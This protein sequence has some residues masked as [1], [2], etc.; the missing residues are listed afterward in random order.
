MERE[1]VPNVSQLPDVRAKLRGAR[2]CDTDETKE[3]R[4]RVN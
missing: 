3:K 4:S 1:G 2:L